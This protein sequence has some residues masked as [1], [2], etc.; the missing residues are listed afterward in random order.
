MRNRLQSFRA[1]TLLRKH[2]LHSGLYARVTRQLGYERFI[3]EQSG[4]RVYSNRSPEP[5]WQ[6]RHCGVVFTG[7]PGWQW[8]FMSYVLSATPWNV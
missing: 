7:K 3:R 8:L 5:T 2:R 1:E 6:G 4:S